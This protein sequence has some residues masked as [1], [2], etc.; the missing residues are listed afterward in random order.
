MALSGSGR[1]ISARRLAMKVKCHLMFGML[2]LTVDQ[3]FRAFKPNQGTTHITAIY[4]LLNILYN[5]FE[6]HM[7]SNPI[8]A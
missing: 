6:L 3:I 4:M 8:P 5:K 1:W 7:F 2:A